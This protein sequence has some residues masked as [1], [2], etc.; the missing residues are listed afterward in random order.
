MFGDFG[1]AVSAPVTKGSAVRSAPARHDEFLDLG[2][3]L[4]GIQALG[5]GPG[6]VENRVTAIQPERVLQCVEAFPGGLI[7]AVRQPTPGLQ[8]CCRAQKALS[9]P[10]VA[11]TSGGAAEAQDAL[12]VP[13]ELLAVL[14]GLKPFA[15]RRWRWRFEPRLD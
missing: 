15:L 8:Q 3:G 12:V 7:A 4:A 6:A 13:I 5:A 14:D 2:D 1:R 9:I 10:P 11:R